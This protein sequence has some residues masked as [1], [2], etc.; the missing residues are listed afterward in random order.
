[1]YDVVANGFIGLVILANVGLAI[2]IVTLA[3]LSAEMC[4]LGIFHLEKM[5]FAFFWSHWMS[6]IVASGPTE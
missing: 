6:D 4:L 1:M 3:H 2:G 5:L